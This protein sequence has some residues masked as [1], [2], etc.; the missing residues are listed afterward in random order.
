MRKLEQ[1]RSELTQLFDSQPLAVLATEGG[2]VPHASLVAFASAEDLRCIYFAT[3]RATRK[4]ANLSANS[5]VSMLVDNRTNSVDDFRRAAAVT[6][7]GR[8]EELDR[9]QEPGAIDKY[10]SKHPHLDE[11]IT[12][13]NC[14]F[15][16]LRVDVYYLVTRFQEVLEI[17]VER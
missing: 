5:N 9:D 1:V 3:T 15:L 13:P 8:A 10:L 17:R 4:Y 12:S 14:A 16:S 2:G 7:T 11:F 6:A